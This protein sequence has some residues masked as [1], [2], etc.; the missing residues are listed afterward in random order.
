MS[1]LKTKIFNRSIQ[2]AIRQHLRKNFSETEKILWRE[3][4]SNQLDVKF[5]RQHG[6]GKY[7]VDLYC[8]E[9]KLIVEVDVNE[10]CELVGDHFLMTQAFSNLIHNAIDFMPESGKLTISAEVKNQRILIN[11][12]NE[13]PQIPEYALPRLYERFYSLPRPYS[14]EKSTGLGLNFVKEVIA[15]HRGEMV[16]QNHENGVIVMIELP[17]SRAV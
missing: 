7:V 12:H 8:P 13:G 11:I 10:K 4:R 3:L 2:K 14:G 1:K 9:K 5:R 15:L 16:I 17:L 6:I